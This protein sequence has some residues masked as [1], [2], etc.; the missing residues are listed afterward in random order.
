MRVGEV[1]RLATNEANYEPA[2]RAS[3]IRALCQHLQAALRFH[4][5]L[6]AVRVVCSLLYFYCTRFRRKSSPTR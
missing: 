1:L 6:K 2:T 4:L 3:N 5:R